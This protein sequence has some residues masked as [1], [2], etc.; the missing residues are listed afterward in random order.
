MKNKDTVKELAELCKHYGLE[1]MKNTDAENEEL[2]RW[3]WN[4]YAS[5][6]NIIKELKNDND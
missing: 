3:A 5:A 6:N 4:I 1:I 2:E